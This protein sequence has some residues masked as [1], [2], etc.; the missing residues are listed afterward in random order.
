LLEF[1]K[2]RKSLMLPQLNAFI[3]GCLAGELHLA[4][5]MPTLCKKLW[6]WYMNIS[7]LWRISHINSLEDKAIK[8]FYIMRSSLA[9]APLSSVEETNK[10]NKRLMTTV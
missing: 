2:V 7:M 4:H 9:V 10:G 3:L 1:A 5:C 6:R 8:T